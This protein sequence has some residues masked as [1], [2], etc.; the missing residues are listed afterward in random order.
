MFAWPFL[1]MRFHFS[2]KGF[3]V[4][5]FLVKKK[6]MVEFIAHKTSLC[7]LGTSLN[8]QVVLYYLRR[9]LLAG[10][11][12]LFSQRQILLCRWN[13]AGMTNW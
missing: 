13:W 11:N 7:P 8:L 1:N 9:T 3:L 12:S 10:N 2:K 6:T 5:G 4:K